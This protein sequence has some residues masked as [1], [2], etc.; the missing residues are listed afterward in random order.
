MSKVQVARCP[1]GW[2]VFDEESQ[3]IV[4]RGPRPEE[5]FVRLVREWLQA[6][7]PQMSYLEMRVRAGEL[8]C[9]LCGGPV[10]LADY[11]H[12]APENRQI[13]GGCRNGSS[14]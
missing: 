12:R 11:N 1:E 9:G 8:S 13:C 2:A 6:P 3:Q 14:K 5:Y 7:P 4:Y 10:T